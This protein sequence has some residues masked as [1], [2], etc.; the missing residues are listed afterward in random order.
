MIST[1]RKNTFIQA[2]ERKLSDNADALQILKRSAS[3]PPGTLH[4]SLVLGGFI[5]EIEFQKTF[6]SASGLQHADSLD[7]FQI[8]TV[9]LERF[10][11]VYFSDREVLP[12]LDSAGRR[13][14]AMASPYNEEFLDEI[15]FLGLAAFEILGCPS[16]V[17]RRAYSRLENTV[18]QHQNDE[19][20]EEF[21]TTEND[22]E[23]ARGL[24]ALVTDALEAQVS[25]IHL[26]PR[27]T[28][29][30]V[31]FRVHGALRQHMLPTNLDTVALLARLKLLA[32]MNVSERRIPQDG[33]VMR[34]FGGRKVEL[35]VSTL[36]TVH[37][38]SLVCRVLDPKALRLGWDKLGFSP[39]IQ[40]TLL[41]LLAKPF[42]L[43]VISGPTA[44]GKTTTLY[45]A[46][47][48]LNDGKK[49]IISVED[50]VEYDLPG[51]EQVQVNAASGASFA[52]IL[53]ATLRH[54][55]DVLMIGEI[56]DAETAEIACRAA[57]VGRL[58]LATIHAN[59]ARAVVD[60]LL[61]LGVSKGLLDQTLLAALEQ[62]LEPSTCLSCE[63]TGC[64]EC[65][66]S[67]L[68]GRK[69]HADVVTF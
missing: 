10:G 23:I 51:I 26:E 5:E 35:R 57:L 40:A 20:S 61:D 3:K 55:P 66:H 37:G 1:S 9:Q 19:S 64:G 44:S 52:A 7:K 63:G 36:P 53:R 6:C 2:L 27:E 68:I 12:L 28:G 21:P 39:T 46:L 47:T 56:R 24:D 58:V 33:R 14:L 69:L 48:H 42:G 29:L 67:G 65:D 22:S 38:E 32:G 31:R 54:D 18:G 11:S 13:Y 15:R 45:T 43:F 41:D 59:T 30:A 60:R 50:P 4:R 62:R 49:K 25:D 34:V 17:L 8:D 16:P